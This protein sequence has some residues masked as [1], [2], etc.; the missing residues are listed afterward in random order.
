MA[1][2]GGGGV[3][4]KPRDRSQRSTLRGGHKR[5]G[6]AGWGAWKELLERGV[7]AETVATFLKV[8]KEKYGLVSEQ[9]KKMTEFK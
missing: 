4:W 9:K 3:M 7:I 2:F 1:G 8:G 5:A 6:L